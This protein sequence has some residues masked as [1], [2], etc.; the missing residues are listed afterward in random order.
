MNDLLPHR[1]V[2]GSSVVESRAATV[3]SNPQITDGGFYNR[4][5]KSK[6]A[7]FCLREVEI[8]KEPPHMY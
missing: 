6:Q 1:A 5:K 3:V 4:W 7:V 2:D 8:F